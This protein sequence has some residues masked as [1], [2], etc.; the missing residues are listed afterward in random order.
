MERIRVIAER[1]LSR[2]YLCDHCLGRL[3]AELLTRV[4]NEERGK[5]V[6]KF[7]AMCV[8][9]GEKIDI[10]PENFYG[11]AFKNVELKVPER[12][13]HCFVC[14]NFFEE[15]LSGIVER[16]LRRLEGYE[17]E[18]FLVGCTPTEEMLAA[19]EKLWE[20]ADV[21]LV[22]SL[23]HEINREVGKRVAEALG[24]KFDTKNPEVIVHVNLREDKISV[25]VRSLFVYGRYKKLVR[26]IPQCKWVC[27]KCRGKGCVECGGMGKL[28]PTSVQEIIEKPLLRLTGGKKSRFH[29]AGREDVDA[30]CLDWR[31]FVIE[32]LKPRVRRVSL[33][34]VTREINASR[35][36]K[37]SGLRVVEDGRVLIKR[38]KSER[39]DKTYEAV[40]T[41]KKP[42]EEEKLRRLRELVR[43]PIVQRTPSRVVH[44]R[45]DKV[46][47]RWVR[48]VEWRVLGR[49]R[50]WLKVR[51][52]AGLYI[53]E[54]IHGDGGRT[55]PSVSELVENEPTKILLDV[56]K[57]HA[58]GL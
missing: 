52:E 24:K 2:V 29:G 50:L 26:G 45:A 30:R 36:V 41:F 53:K 27:S 13:P 12:K 25:Q 43:K 58:R 19:E 1:V 21:R 23:R 35:K 6:R 47:K 9:S 55:R 40:V 3:F 49:R 20:V 7:L 32:I 22:E 34:R 10:L 11:I 56:V 54:L 57:I 42:I 28:Y 14:Q 48:K 31:P 4:S 16:I 51:A 5:S 37:V 46:R 39:F 44:R 38:L 15:R 17:F 18:T 8:D 33:R